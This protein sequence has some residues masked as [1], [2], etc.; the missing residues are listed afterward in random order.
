MRRWIPLFVLTAAIGCAPKE[1]A[2]EA[3]PAPTPKDAA[4]ASRPAGG[5]VAPMASG[6]ATGMTPV[7]GAESVG[8]SGMGG[9]GNAA[10]DAARRAAST[11]STPNLGTGDE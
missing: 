11:P 2:P 8:G 3:T 9:L 7:S 10:K 5:S 6:A 1:P 4:S